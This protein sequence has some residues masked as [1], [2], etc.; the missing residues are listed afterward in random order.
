MM[1]EHSTWAVA[2]LLQAPDIGA[3]TPQEMRKTRLGASLADT[4]TAQD[5]ARRRKTAQD[6]AKLLP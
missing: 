5:G 6:L 3:I 2:A 4:K 1:Q